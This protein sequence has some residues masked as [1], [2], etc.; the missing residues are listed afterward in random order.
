MSKRIIIL[1]LILLL[2]LTSCS[3]RIPSSESGKTDFEKDTDASNI[4]E[5]EEY[6]TKEIS[7][8]EGKELDKSSSNVESVE[9]SPKEI[10]PDESYVGEWRRYTEVDSGY[11]EVASA[12]KDSV[13]FILSIH[14]GTWISATAVYSDGKYVFGE[15][16]STNFVYSHYD[17][18]VLQSDETKGSGYLTVL[19]GG[20]VIIFD[21]GDNAEKAVKAVFEEN[22][23]ELDEILF[24]DLGAYGTLSKNVKPYSNEMI[25][26]R[27]I[28]ANSG[29]LTAVIRIIYD[30]NT[31]EWRHAD[32][33]YYHQDGRVL[34][35]EELEQFMEDHGKTGL[36]LP[37]DDSD[38]LEYFA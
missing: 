3:V 15:E 16:I 37:A 21:N 11:I 13:K 17:I 29:N 14:K 33:F 34:Q 30:R 5:I 4:S 8:V 10:I 25:P 12:D 35:G 26:L 2:T 38:L 7:T 24:F 6:D 9:S 28:I 31:D 19:D 1:V 22:D 36:I 23:W 20:I 18:K 32:T 27:S